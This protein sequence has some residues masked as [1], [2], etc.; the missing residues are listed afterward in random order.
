MLFRRKPADV[1]EDPAPAADVDTDESRPLPRGYT[2]PKGRQTPKRGPTQV[3]RVAEPAPA[4]RRE[5]AKR[6]R[7]RQRADRAEAMEGMRRGDPRFLPPRDRGEE[8]ALVRDI[9]DSRRTM[10][11]WFFGGALL[12]IIGSSR[13]MPVEVQL[14]S[15]ALWIALALAVIVDSVLIVRKIKRLVRARYPKTDQRMGSL[16]IYGIMRAMTFRRMRIPKPRVTIGQQ[17]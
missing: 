6:M 12:V 17:V 15:N 11:T 4:N 8:R 7:E 10:G 16:Y 13:A 14:A 2:P 9:V 3:R 5:A 1:V